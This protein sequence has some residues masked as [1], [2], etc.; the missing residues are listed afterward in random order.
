MAAI[1]QFKIKITYNNGYQICDE[2]AKT[3]GQ[4][5]LQIEKRDNRNFNYPLSFELIQPIYP[6]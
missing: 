3:F 4:A 6:K 5:C 1:K 2:Q